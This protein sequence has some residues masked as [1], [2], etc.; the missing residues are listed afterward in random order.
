MMNNIGQKT[1]LFCH[2]LTPRLP[3]YFFYYF[4]LLPAPLPRCLSVT[5][6]D[7][8]AAVW[9]GLKVSWTHGLMHRRAHAHGWSMWWAAEWNE[10]WWHKTQKRSTPPALPDPACAIYWS[11]SSEH[12]HNKVNSSMCRLVQC[13]RAQLAPEPLKKFFIPCVVVSLR[14]LKQIAVSSSPSQTSLML[15]RMICI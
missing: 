13:C 7:D 9:C 3:L 1:K 11:K 14:L 5:C 10:R 15:V 8:T 12:F 2:I 6:S 4:L